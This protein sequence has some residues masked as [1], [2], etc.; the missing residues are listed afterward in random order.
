M[1]WEQPSNQLLRVA[2]QR[3]G[4]TEEITL[5]GELDL[6]SVDVL[7]D[8]IRLAIDDGVRHLILH[9]AELEFVDSTGLSCFL[10]ASKRLDSVGGTCTLRSPSPQVRR[11]LSIA[12]VLLAL[13]GTE[14]DPPTSV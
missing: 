6:S 12:G 3:S 1:S 13:V 2:T 7:Y 8:H 5:S 10:S 11:T 4:T 14:D 9:V